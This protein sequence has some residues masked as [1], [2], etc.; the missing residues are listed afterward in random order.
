MSAPA[1]YFVA[2]EA[3][4]EVWIWRENGETPLAVIPYRDFGADPAL[5]AYIT[6]EMPHEG[7]S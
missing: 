1:G 7:A 2:R 4:G 6:S 3:N 5:W